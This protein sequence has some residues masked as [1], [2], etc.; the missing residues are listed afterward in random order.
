M[1]LKFLAHFWDLQEPKQSLCLRIKTA[2]SVDGAQQCMVGFP[3]HEGQLVM[4]AIVGVNKIC[5]S[6]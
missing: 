4:A 2:F 3:S 6:K 5:T 1:L